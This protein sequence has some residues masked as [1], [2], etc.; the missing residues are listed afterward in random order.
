MRKKSARGAPGIFFFCL[1]G[2]GSGRILCFAVWAGDVL[3]LSVGAGDRRSLTYWPAWVVLKGHNNQKKQPKRPS[4]INK[5][6]TGSVLAM[7]EDGSD[8]HHFCY[9][10]P[11]PSDVALQSLMFNLPTVATLITPT[12]FSSHSFQ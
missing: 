5:N 8:S 9:A 10:Y 4:S 7:R 12:F 1:G 6:N 11:R 3:F 2:A